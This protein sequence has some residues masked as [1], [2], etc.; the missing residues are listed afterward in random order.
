[1]RK[2]IMEWLLVKYLRTFPPIAKNC[3]GTI[4]HLK[5]VMLMIPINIVGGRQTEEMIRD[6]TRKWLLTT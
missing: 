6:I 2:T 4:G 1:M 3:N 5:R